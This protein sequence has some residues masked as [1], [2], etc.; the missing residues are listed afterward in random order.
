MTDAMSRKLPMAAILA[1]AAGSAFDPISDGPRSA[2]Q[3]P[4]RKGYKQGKKAKKAAR[5]QRQRARAAL[6]GKP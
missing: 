1:L 2:A 6:E 3:Q 4:R 5:K